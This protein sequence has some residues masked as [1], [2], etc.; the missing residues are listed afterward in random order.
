MSS[1]EQHIENQMRKRG[2]VK[3]QGIAILN[4]VA[5]TETEKEILSPTLSTQQAV[6]IF[7]NEFGEGWQLY[8]KVKDLSSKQMSSTQEARKAKI[9][10]ELSSEALARKNSARRKIEIIT[11]AKEL[12]LNPEDLFGGLWLKI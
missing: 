1:T 8:R 4:D 11:E 2:Y 10:Q 12:G 7:N 3:V 6:D 9:N 5:V